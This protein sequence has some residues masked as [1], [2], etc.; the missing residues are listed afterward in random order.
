MSNEDERE[1]TKPA[2]LRVVPDAVIR[3]DDDVRE[4]CYAIWST[5]AYMSPARTARW[6]AR[7]CQDVAHMPNADT[8]AYWARR[9]RWLERSQED[10]RRFHGQR[11]LRLQQKWFAAV[12]GSADVMLDAQAGAYDDNP[13]AGLVRM[14]AGEL[15]IRAVERRVLPLMPPKPQAAP[16]ELAELPL[17][18]AESAL[19]DQLQS[20]KAK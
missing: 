17:E 19:R 7:E 16:Q 3:Y 12:E 6:F 8:I 13:A 2:P 1:E 15:A 14:K 20:R 5:V 11:L 4:T 10:E 9:D 18:E